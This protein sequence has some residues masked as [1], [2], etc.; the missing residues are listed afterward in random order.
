MA[1]AFVSRPFRASQEAVLTP[2][3]K[4]DRLEVVK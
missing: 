3:C 2:R 1:A 4:C